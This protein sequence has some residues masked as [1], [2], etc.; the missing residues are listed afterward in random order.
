MAL[1]LHNTHRFERWDPTTV[2]SIQAWWD[3]N[4]I[5]TLT[6]SSGRVSNADNKY[7][8]ANFSRIDPTGGPTLV[9]AFGRDWLQFGNA[10]GLGADPPDYM[11]NCGNSGS[12]HPAL[13][14][15]ADEFTMSIVF[16]S[17]A[18][19][20]PQAL[21]NR[22]SGTNGRYKL[23]LHFPTSNDVRAY[24]SSGGANIC[25]LRETANTHLADG[26]PKVL[27]IIRNNVSGFG[28]CWIN[29][30]FASQLTL[31]T[32]GDIDEPGTSFSKM[33]LGGNQTAAT[34]YPESW[35]GR[36]GEILF[37][38]DRLEGDDL[39]NLHYYL[40]GKWGAV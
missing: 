19:G 22:G 23:G 34:T 21:F 18:S 30:V 37:F 2:A 9:T 1:L 15:D 36:I 16:T 32:L 3:F 6:I 20:T 4:D 24:L 38:G 29:G 27:T 25:D 26:N 7:G 39:L 31:G 8:G 17:T 13:Q 12:E 35:Q 33:V 40:V 28:E 14:F 11:M 5:S 10:N